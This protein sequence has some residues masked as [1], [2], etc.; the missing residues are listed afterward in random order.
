MDTAGLAVRMYE[1]DAYPLSVC[2][3]ILLPRALLARGMLASRRQGSAPLDCALSKCAV[4][5]AKFIRFGTSLE[6][7][8]ARKACPR[9]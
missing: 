5:L 1:R 8:R 7:P 2:C 9:Q 6:T 4:E 3:N